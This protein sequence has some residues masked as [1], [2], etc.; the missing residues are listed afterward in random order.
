[1]EPDV[2]HRE[3][4]GQLQVIFDDL[5]EHVLLHGLL[6]CMDDGTGGLGRRR[7]VVAV[8]PVKEQTVDV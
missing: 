5:L 6:D 4:A 3:V 2:V 7:T 8:G 1:V